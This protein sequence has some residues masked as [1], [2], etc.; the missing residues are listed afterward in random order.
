MHRRDALPLFVF[1]ACLGLMFAA[2]RPSLG[3]MWHNQHGGPPK[4][5][6]WDG[7][8]SLGGCSTCVAPT[9]GSPVDGVNTFN[10]DLT[11]TD[12]PVSYKSVGDAFPFTITYNADYARPSP[13]GSRWSNSYN[14]YV[15][16]DAPYGAIVIESNGWENYFS[17]DP[18]PGSPYVSP[19]WVTDTLEKTYQ[20][21]NW[22]GWRLTRASQEY[23]TFNTSGQLTRRTDT[24]GISWTFTYTSGLLTTATDPKGRQTTLSY[25]NGNL[26]Q[27]TVPGNL[28][29][30]FGY[31]T[32]TP[33]RLTTV[34]DAADYDYSYG[35]DA[36]NRVVS[37]VDPSGRQ[38]E[39]TYYADGKLETTFITGLSS[40]AKGYSYTPQTNGQLYVDITETKDGQNRVT[41][42]VYENT[43]DP[44]SGRY[45]GTLLFIIVD[46]GSSPHLNA[47]RGWAYDSSFR[48]VRYRDSYQAETGGKAH[49]HFYYYTDADNPTLV[50]KYIDP[51]NSDAN[52]TETGTPSPGCPGYLY[53][54]D[55]RGNKTRETT[56][57]GRVTDYTYYAG[58]SRLYQV[59]V[60]DQD[61]NGNPVD[62]ITSYTYWDMTYRFQVKT[63]TDARG[64]VTT[65]YYDSNCYLDYIDPPLG[66]N[67]QYT[68]NSVGDVTAVTDGNGNTTSYQ[69]DG[70]HRQTQIT[71]PDIGAGQKTKT[72]SYSC[73]DIDQVTDENGIVTKYEYDEYT[74]RLWK[75]HEDYAGL[76]Y[77]TENTYDEVGNLK[78]VKNARGKITTYTYDAGNR[79]T[80]ASYPDSTSESWTYRDDGRVWTH[81]DGRGR[82][83]TYR[84][85][86]DDRPAGPYAGG[87]PAIN[88][89]N[90]TD[91]Y[92]TR[93][94]DGLI[95]EVRDASGTTTRVYYPS[96]WLK[97]VT[98]SAGTT[99]T[100]T[101]QYNGVGLASSLQV[102]GESAFSYGYNG[103]NQLSSATNPDSVQVTFSYDNGGRRTD[104]TRTGSTIHYDYNARNWLTAVLNRTTGGVARYNAT[105]YYQD[106]S[107]WD[108]TGNP[109][110]R[111][112][113]FGGLDYTTTL[114]YDHI[115][116]QTEETKKDSGGATL[117]TLSYGYD[118]VGN[119]TTRTLGGTTY[120]YIYDDNNKMT[121]ASGGGLTA[122]FGYDNNGNMTSVSGTMYGAKTMGF[123]D[124]NRMTS[125]TYGGVT[126][127]YYYNWTGMR[128]R[129]R[130]GG[131][132][133]RYLYN[134]NRVLEEL[135]DSGAMTARYTTES[136][137]YYGSLLHT[138]RA[139]GE[140]RF[141][142]YDEIGSVRGLVDASGTVTDSYEL[143]TFG[144]QVSSTGTTPNS[145]R[146]GGAWGYITDPSGFLQLGV[147]FFWPE[148]G[149]FI[150]LDPIG[151]GVDWYAFVENNPTGKTDPQGLAC[152]PVGFHTET[153]SYEYWG[154]WHQITCSAS[155][156]QEGLILVVQMIIRFHT[157]W[158]DT[159]VTECV[160]LLCTG[161][162][163]IWPCGPS[164]PTLVRR[165]RC[166]DVMKTHIPV[167]YE[168]FITWVGPK[169][170]IG[171]P[172]G[173]GL[174]C[175]ADY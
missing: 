160:D 5:H 42:H 113:S 65:Y 122:S 118:A 169:G 125:I 146:F 82:T 116:R 72:T 76:N 104:V 150:S 123:N 108:H 10:G 15:I 163:W 102:T 136:G 149:R 134:G 61:V 101:Y 129:A 88:Y 57:E 165:T 63:I 48:K 40:S 97:T 51:E 50:T 32:S 29:A 114:R 25:T 168:Q 159:I 143:D 119:R 17:G 66:N 27:V 81:T 100:V 161:S 77:V 4:C 59:I 145:Y 90:D 98:T 95:T 139:T 6:Q 19:A 96:T 93:D 158:R 46:P 124:D 111:V 164:I 133:Y 162:T 26:T 117:Y 53:E 171:W 24:Q 110:K 39:Y 70:I 54:Y 64:N 140:S 7:P 137:S 9:A 45:V 22:N 68:C 106:G 130:L 153:Q 78:T 43:D 115:P 175:I 34:T 170:G 99:K 120:S 152:V 71:Y 127:Y 41:R 141:P 37:I 94:K 21:G 84:Y 31:D 89:P 23:L 1:A 112:E 121:S 109:L 69:Y 92:I 47:T 55:S 18:A 28:H 75:V 2:A 80:Q 166:F 79:K 156:S 33:P 148:V 128:Y 142:L 131:T 62:R 60:R 36:S 87:Y 132:Y 13:M 85:D 20:M 151:S 44:I 154:P 12:T 56:P 172:P 91:V 126:D 52:P 38:V 16:N 173:P 138:K 105:Y 167:G 144:R 86:A 14:T 74:H 155:Y 30:D 107:L 58:T 103:R 3:H 157:K 73:C 147:R 35:Y 8:G 174:S 67:L 49:R 83:I 135:N 11:I